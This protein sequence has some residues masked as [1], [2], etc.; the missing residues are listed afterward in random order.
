MHSIQE[1]LFHP[2][3]LLLFPLQVL[4]ASFPI[5][6]RLVRIGCCTNVLQ[7]LLHVLQRLGC[8]EMLQTDQKSFV[9]IHKVPQLLLNLGTLLLLY[10][11][12]DMTASP[13]KRLAIA[14]G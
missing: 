13:R 4:S 12:E 5:S 9:V 10:S 6:I 2:G 8:V 1:R 7:Q 14:L 3:D 11:D